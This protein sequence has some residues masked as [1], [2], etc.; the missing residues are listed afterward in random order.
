MPSYYK[1]NCSLEKLKYNKIFD[2]TTQSLVY[3]NNS[4][5]NYIFKNNNVP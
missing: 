1:I 4:D 3:E 2:T 5:S